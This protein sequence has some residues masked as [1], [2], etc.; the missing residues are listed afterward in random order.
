MKKL[1]LA[2]AAIILTF[3]SVTA[4]KGTTFSISGNIGPATTTD[5]TIAFGADLQAAF[6]VGSGFDITVS[7]GYESFSYK[8]NFGNNISVTG[9]SS[10]IPLLAGAK[11]FFSPKFYG[12]GKL[13]YSFSTLSGGK[14]A[15]TYSPILGYVISQNIDLFAQYLGLSYSGNSLS[16]VLAG[17]RINFD[18]K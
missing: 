11:V 10:Y 14:G 2:F 1:F 16:A 3:A 9:H 12:H 8:I 6:P 4:Q 18:G 13:G 5:F 15:F 7:A 17:I